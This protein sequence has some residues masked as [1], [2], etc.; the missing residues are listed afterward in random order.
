L[1][2]TICDPGQIE[3][4]EQL[5]TKT[6]T[7][8][9]GPAEGQLIG[10]LVNDLMASPDKE[11]IIG[12]IATEEG[13]IIAGI[14]FTRLIFESDVNAFILAP[15][16][17]HTD[18][19]GK[20]VGQALIRYGLE[21]MKQDGVELLVTYGDINFYSRVGFQQIDESIIK[22]PLPLTYPEGWLAQSL[23]SDRITPIPGTSQCVP[24]FN[25]PEYW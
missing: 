20:G 10:N 14:F 25:K 7:D 21:S 17:V 8:S 4:I 13:E 6:F 11:N 15:V 24:E 22:A 1:K 19:Q 23:L 12:F 2:L 9:E 3:E 18:H 16:A 5:F